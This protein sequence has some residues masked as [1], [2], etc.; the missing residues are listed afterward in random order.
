MRYLTEIN[1]AFGNL[2]THKLRAFLTM[3]GMIF[4]VGAVIAML[5]ISAGAERQTLALIDALGV[6]NV[7]VQV[8][9]P[10]R[11]AK[12]IELRKTSVGLTE[13]DARA[14]AKAVPNVTRVA[15]KAL[16]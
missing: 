13:R 4:G 5:S 10:T 7:M 6:R 1:L 16:I 9:E 14:I 15:Q 11:D 2:Y 3:L 12:L 8:K